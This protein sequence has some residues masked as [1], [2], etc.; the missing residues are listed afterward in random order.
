MPT[1]TLPIFPLTLV[2]FPGAPQL[3]HIFEPRY[4]QLLADCQAGDHRF[5]VS[6]VQRV[7]DG[8]PVPAVGTV[9]CSARIHTV[10]P[11]PDG[12]SNLLVF[13]EH[14]Y[15]LRGYEDTNR[16]YRVGLVEPFDDEPSAGTERVQ[17][18]ATTVSD[19]FTRFTSALQ[20]LGDVPEQQI[21]I[22]DDPIALS[23]Y[24]AA[25]LDLDLDLKQ[26]LLELRSTR[27]RLERLS[28]HLQRL[29]AQT[30]RRVAVHRR[31]KRNGR[32]G[33]GRPRTVHGR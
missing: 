16:Q 22:P 29:H 11:Q 30:A 25:A 27:T 1:L 15:V 12:R 33:N 9:G 2:L 13:G 32:G 3:L 26:S 23:F 5:G 17:Q 21:S 24:V 18:L 10:W 4:R 8:D 20:S 19:Q 31:A 14:R 7:G 6:L 28:K